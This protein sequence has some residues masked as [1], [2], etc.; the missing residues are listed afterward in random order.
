MLG[1]NYPLD[2]VAYFLTGILRL[3]FGS[4]PGVMP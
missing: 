1:Y 3:G 2:E 4:R